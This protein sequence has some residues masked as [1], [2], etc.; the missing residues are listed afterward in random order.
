MTFSDIVSGQYI[1]L[2]NMKF[3]P[4]VSNSHK[5]KTKK[6]YARRRKEPPDPRKARVGRKTLERQHEDFEAQHERRMP[7][8][9]CPCRW[10][11]QPAQ[12]R[13]V[14]AFSILPVYIEEHAQALVARPVDDA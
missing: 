14:N 12:I 13:V 1:V 7:C 6:S 2:L 3:T 4:M 5:S 8:E 9:A 10:C 11:S